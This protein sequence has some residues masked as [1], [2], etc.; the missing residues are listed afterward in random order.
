M[1]EEP[2]TEFDP[3]QTAARFAGLTR[4]DR[5]DI[6]ELSSTAETGAALIQ[7]NTLELSALGA[8][9]DLY[10][11]WNS[12]SSNLAAWIEQGSGG[13]VTKSVTVRRGY[14]FPLGH[15]AVIVDTV[16]RTVGVDPAQDGEPGNYPIAY[17]QQQT[18]VQVTQ[19]VKN[20][21]ATGQPF[22]IDAADG[23]TT[24]WPFTSVRMVTLTSPSI[25]NTT[26]DIEYLI[27]NDYQ[28]R[29]LTTGDVGKRSDV[30]W[31]FVATDAAGHD[32]AFSMPLA[33]VYGYD[34]NGRN[35]APGGS[36]TSSFSSEYSSTWTD[37]V[38]KAYLADTSHQKW[39]QVGG[40][41]RFAPELPSKAESIG[42]TTHPALLIEFGAATTDTDANASSS[43]FSEV[44]SEAT[45]AGAGQPNFFPTI[46]TARIR[47]HAADTMAGGDFKDARPSG[48]PLPNVGGV[49][50]K[51]YPDYV[52][53]G[54]S[55]YLSAAGAPQDR[56]ERAARARLAITS[57]PPNPGAVYAQFVNKSPLNLPAANSGGIGRPNVAL[58]GLSAIQGAVGGT[59]STF[60]QKA[61]LDATD[62]FP[63][64]QAKTSAVIASF[65]GG[66]SLGDI[67]D[68]ANFQT[69]SVST[70]VDPAGGSTV[71]YTLVTPLGDYNLPGTASGD[72]NYLF[73][74]DT[75]SGD[76]GDPIIS[77]NGYGN[78]HLTAVFQVPTSV[79]GAAAPAPAY[80]INGTIDP[81]TIYLMGT[82]T[83]GFLE[84]HFASVSFSASNA[85]GPN[86]VV[87]IDTTNFTG[88]LS[89]INGL[90]QFIESLGGNGLQLSVTPSQVLLT[91][92]LSIP[93]QAIGIF[94]LSGLTFSA[95]ISIPL[96]DGQA[97]AQFAFASQANPA[98]LTVSCFGGGIFVAI[99]VGFGGVKSISI[100]L[101]FTGQLAID[102]VVAS[103]SVSLVAG[104]YI[105]YTPYVLTDPTSGLSLTGYVRITGM[106][107]LLG[108]LTVSAEIDLSLTYDSSSG[109]AI[110][111]ALFIG[112]VSICGFSK[113]VSFSVTK[114]FGGGGSSGTSSMTA[115]VRRAL[116][117]G[118][119]PSAD[120]VS[121]GVQITF[122]DL[123]PTQGNWT[124]YCTAFGG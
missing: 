81:F 83:F 20:Y 47:V 107:Q 57:T 114:R 33:F 21:P 75:A 19:P 28:A 119:A 99:G 3:G 29:W 78:L 65:L 10:G 50:F 6:V 30:V 90:E 72:T 35:G 104:I 86:V 18:F 32:I 34:K 84:L 122:D 49:Q 112:S 16:F 66:L 117:S 111:T 106:I 97:L 4:E 105:T 53:H 70:Q 5:K 9:V 63:T 76:T 44:A 69:P 110:G 79:N 13:R 7:A 43:P 41:I 1:S 58:T 95:N 17:L 31:D 45:L 113:T 121:P 88:A 64:V 26:A 2:T 22:V 46:R 11:A 89:F 73:H 52:Q 102:V 67:L 39:S 14:L 77:P 23:V 85:G 42:Q 123:F 116:D 98:T 82:G 56:A 103:G 15:E 115:Q 71:T 94:S 27:K 91:L 109:A 68:N 124:T 60:A 120:I 62:Y 54:A 93:D 38:V 101:D 100:G 51:Y 12:S 74:P 8:N 92:S 118:D 87:D 37:K 61:A 40:H 59:L 96:Y 36:N 25:D 80:Q 55:N 108:I 24:D 48:D